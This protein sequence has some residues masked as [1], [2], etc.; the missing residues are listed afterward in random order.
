M[1]FYPFDAFYIFLAIFFSQQ[2]GS[3]RNE[4]GERKK[5]VVEKM[6]I[7]EFKISLFLSRFFSLNKK[8]NKNAHCSLMSTKNVQLSPSF[9]SNET[10]LQQKK[11]FICT[12]FKSP[13]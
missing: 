10:P 13:K 7:Q 1:C 2:N 3:N 8:A 6:D 4:M 9:F 5:G 11:K 12:I